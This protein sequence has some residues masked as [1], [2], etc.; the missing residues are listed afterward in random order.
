MM[1]RRLFTKRLEKGRP[2]PADGVAAISPAWL[3]YLLSG[4]D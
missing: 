4:I 2:S 3:G 1:E